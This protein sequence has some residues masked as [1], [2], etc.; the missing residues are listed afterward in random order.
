[1]TT[2]DLTP[3]AASR[4]TEHAPRWVRSLGLVY[5]STAFIGTWIF[6]TWFVI[7]L[8]N[9]PK[10]TDPWVSPSADMGPAPD[11]IIAAFANFGLILLFCVQHSVMARP[12]FKR[13]ITSVIPQALERATY[14]HAANITGFLF[15]YFW[16]PMPWVVWSVESSALASILWIAFGVGWVLLLW[17]AVSINLFELLGLNQAWVWFRGQDPKPLKLETRWIF[18]YVEHPMYVG[19]LLGVWMTP[20]MSV[21]H[22]LM[23][24]VFTAYIATAMLL[25]RRDLSAKF[26]RPY[27]DWRNGQAGCPF[28]RAKKFRDA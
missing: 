8:G 2:L 18:R 1:M 4:S 16:T 21:G 14:V 15:L 17:G 10:R 9:L 28:S 7:F 12:A 6:F 5:A 24:S 22:L 13:R 27:V 23:A 3:R 20:H 25:E 11:P 19:V 26:G